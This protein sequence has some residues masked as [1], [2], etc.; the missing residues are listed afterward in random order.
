[1]IQRQVRAQPSVEELALHA[2]FPGVGDFGLENIMH[3]ELAV[4]GRDR[5]D[6]GLVEAAAAKPTAPAAVEG[7]VVG[8]LVAQRAFGLRGV[9]GRIAYLAG[10]RGTERCAAGTVPAY[11]WC[12][13]A[14]LVVADGRIELPLLVELVGRIAE[15]RPGVVVLRVRQERDVGVGRVRIGR[16]DQRRL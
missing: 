7:Q 3:T 6:A 11:R 5:A 12:S 4:G 10:V 1:M 14:V 13:R 8:R 2:D 16:I 9:E 15:Y